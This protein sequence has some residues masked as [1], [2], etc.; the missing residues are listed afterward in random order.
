MP[1]REITG[2][3]GR[4]EALLEEPAAAG[5]IGHDGRVSPGIPPA[6]APRWSSRTR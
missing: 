6:C 5:S 1:P 3:V 2:P 4:L